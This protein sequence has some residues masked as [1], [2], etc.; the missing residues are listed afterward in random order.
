MSYA[1][2]VQGKRDTWRN[3]DAG[4]KVAGV[5]PSRLTRAKAKNY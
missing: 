1:E 3:T 5:R 2:P 4:N